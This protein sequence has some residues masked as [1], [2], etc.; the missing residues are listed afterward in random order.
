M[1]FEWNIFPGTTYHITAL[2]QSPRVL[3]KF[4]RRT[5]IFHMTDYLQVDVQRHLVGDLKTIKRN[6]NQVLMLFLSPW[7][8]IFSRTMV[9]SSSE[10]KWYSTH[11]FKPQGDWDRVA[12]QMLIKFAESQH[13]QYCVPRVHCPEERSKA[14][15]VDNY[16]HPSALMRGRLKLSHNYFCYSSLNIYGAVSDFCEFN[17]MP[18][19]KG[20][21]YYDRTIWPIVCAKSVEKFERNTRAESLLTI[22]ALNPND[23]KKTLK[24]ITG[25]S[26]ADWAGNPVT[27]NSTSCTLLR[28]SISLDEWMSRTGGLLPCPMEKL[29]MK[30]L[31][32]LSAEL[33]FA[34]A[35]L[36]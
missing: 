20:E 21:F 14:K 3:V 9:Y 19:E 4:E 24:H 34:H 6:A 36:K 18:C 17:P 23:L 8:E 30:T 27:K 12:E 26:D 11:D 35:I 7:E 16:Q 22:P 33:I 28:W 15:V 25:Y 13:T 5:R 29:E 31:G 1:D 10:K 32:A 2:Q